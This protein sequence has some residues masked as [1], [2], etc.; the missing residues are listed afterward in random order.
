MR[1]KTWNKIATLFLYISFLIVCLI[2][3]IL[4]WDVI[5]KGGRHLS[6]E[7]ISTMPKEGMTEGGVLPAIV[8]TVLVTLICAIISVPF[9]VACA[10]YLHEYSKDNILTRFIRVSVRNLAG[11]P[12]I[13]YGLFGVALFVD[14]F[15]FGT[16]VLSAG[17]TLALMSL[18]WTITASEEALR[19]VPPSYRQG[20]FALGAT[21]W[22]TIWNNV[23]PPAFS[24]ILTGAILGVA[25]AMGETAPILFTG[26]AFYLPELSFSLMDEFMALPYHL[27]IMSTQHHSTELVRPLSYATALVLLGLVFIMNLQ[28]VL[29][30][31]RF[32]KK[33]RPR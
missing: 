4:A 27:Y 30:R 26:V 22:Q 15:S 31:Y 20:A 24:G 17:L 28:A 29:I 11:V 12:S 5:W 33:Y 23:L 32:R 18:P 2:I 19:S 13:V 14:L 7:F 9:G 25:R 8:G 6:W 16:S 21:R 3:V 10:I 1:A